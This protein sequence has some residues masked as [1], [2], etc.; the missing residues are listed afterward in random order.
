M[1]GGRMTL[2]DLDGDGT[3]IRVK[4][5]EKSRA[6]NQKT[7]YNIDR[8][9]KDRDNLI[10]RGEQLHLAIQFECYPE[11]CRQAL[12]KAKLK[13]EDVLSRLP[14]FAE[15]YQPWNSEAKP[16]VRQLLPDRLADFV[17]LYE[18]PKPRKNI[19]YENYRIEDYLQRLTVTR[20]IEGERI[21]G[22]DAAILS[23]ASS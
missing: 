20:G 11:Q 17:R 22:P 2:A 21:I 12:N 1:V 23:S 15:A 6:A 14:S 13:P 8:Y 19:S 18:K 7:I 3:S 16:L 9:N 4:P 5:V 10:T